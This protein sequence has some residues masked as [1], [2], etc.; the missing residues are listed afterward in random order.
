MPPPLPK[1]PPFNVAQPLTQALQFHHKGRLAEAEPLYAE[2]LRA[3]PDHFDALQM[4]GLIKVAKGQ[5][6]EALQLV[7][8]AMRSRKPSPQILLNYG[9]ILNRH[10]PDDGHRRADIAS[11]GGHRQPRAIVLWIEARREGWR[12]RTTHR[13]CRFR[14]H[15]N[16][17]LSWFLLERMTTE[18]VTPPLVVV[19][20]EVR[21]SAAGSLRTGLSVWRPWPSGRRHSGHG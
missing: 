11:M 2:I 10:P 12:R 16:A 18:P 9:M 8:A 3:R 5:P 14:F 13:E 15:Q 1:A 21:R 6:A 4:M 7:S 20:A 19:A 17:P